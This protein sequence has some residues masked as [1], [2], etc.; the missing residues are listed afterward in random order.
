MAHSFDMLT[1][2]FLLKPP[3]PFTGLFSE[4]EA[5]YGAVTCAG[6]YGCLVEN[7]CQM[8]CHRIHT[9]IGFH[10]LGFCDTFQY[11]LF[12]WFQWRSACHKDDI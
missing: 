4:L 5:S 3:Q 7:P 12:C 1:F 9:D 6:S 10:H 11:A 8:F 2:D